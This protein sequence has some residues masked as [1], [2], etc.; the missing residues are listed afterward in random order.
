M[1]IFNT[2]VSEDKILDTGKESIQRTFH[3]LLGIA[4]AVLAGGLF[5]VF[6]AIIAPFLEDGTEDIKDVVSSCYL[7]FA[8]H[9]L[10]TIT[11]LVYN[12]IR[13]R[14]ADPL[15][16]GKQVIEKELKMAH[17]KELEERRLA[18]E[19][20][21]NSLLNHNKSNY[22][23]DIS[24]RKFAFYVFQ[25]K[26]S[27]GQL[28]NS[29]FRQSNLNRNPKEFTIN[30]IV[31]SNSRIEYVQNYTTAFIN[32]VI[33]YKYVLYLQN[34]TYLINTI[35]MNLNGLR[36]KE[37]IILFDNNGV[38][39][40]ASE[41]TLKEQCDAKVATFVSEEAEIKTQTVV[42]KELID[43]PRMI[44]HNEFGTVRE[45]E[46]RKY[47]YYYADGHVE[48]PEGEEEWVRDLPPQ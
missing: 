35:Q 6:I 43:G 13:K 27:F 24:I 28:F 11:L 3:V 7:L 32:R 31:I 47:R 17:E 5:W 18:Y 30:N 44:R 25:E 21:F 2:E 40:I 20:E 42:R 14:K 19:K 4:S 37:T 26:N 10:A 41:S 29:I 23:T 45:Y 16:I 33:L 1:K 12:I 39:Y 22:E 38:P 8:L 36:D 46:Y 48:E 9:A 15:E 34:G